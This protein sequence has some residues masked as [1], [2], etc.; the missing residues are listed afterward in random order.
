MRLLV[1]ENLSFRLPASLADDFPGSAQVRDVGLKGGKDG[2]VWEYAKA[3][4]LCILTK[5]LD[6]Q[7]RSLLSESP[8]KVILVRLGNCSTARVQIAMRNSLDAIER[9]ERDPAV[10]I[11]VIP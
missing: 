10:A 8:P 9:L 3:H 4:N 2:D 11:L 5:D 1:D 6:F 7:A